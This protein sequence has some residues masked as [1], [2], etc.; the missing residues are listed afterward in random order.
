M[1]AGTEGNVRENKIEG[2]EARGKQQIPS[3]ADRRDDGEQATASIPEINL[4]PAVRHN[5]AIDKRIAL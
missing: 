3:A 4:K 1:A 2:V 5:Y